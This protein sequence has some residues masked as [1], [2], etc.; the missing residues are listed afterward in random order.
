M[1][2]PPF[3]QGRT[4]VTDK[5]YGYAGHCIQSAGSNSMQSHGVKLLLHLAWSESDRRR[6]REGGGAIADRPSTPVQSDAGP[7]SLPPDDRSISQVVAQT[8]MQTV[9]GRPGL[10]RWGTWE[11]FLRPFHNYSQ[12]WK[13]TSGLTPTTFPTHTMGFRDILDLIGHYCK[14]ILF[15]NST[16]GPTPET[17]NGIPTILSH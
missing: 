9:R 8:C 6:G 2:I 17:K 1:L 10:L 13:S 11:G 16:F 12:F 5:A 7:L 4:A 3:L 14:Y 15:P